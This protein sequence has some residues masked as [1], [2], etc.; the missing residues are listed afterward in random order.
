MEKLSI[1]C[2]MSMQHGADMW[3]TESQT[4]EQNICFSSIWSYVTLHRVAVH[5]GYRQKGWEVAKAKSPRAVK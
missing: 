5:P 4:L 1:C 3:E 2:P